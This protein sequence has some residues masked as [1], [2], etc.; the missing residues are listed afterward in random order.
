MKTDDIPRE[1]LL[2]ML[3]EAAWYS[4]GRDCYKGAQG[5]SYDVCEETSIRDVVYR[6]EPLFETPQEALIAHWQRHYPQPTR[7]TGD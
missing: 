1:H 2:A 4:G 5:Y 3:L 6:D 7:G